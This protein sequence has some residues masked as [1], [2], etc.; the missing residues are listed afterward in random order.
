MDDPHPKATKRKN[1]SD[2]IGFIF[3][4]QI[5]EMSE[6]YGVPEVRLDVSTAHQMGNPTGRLAV[7]GTLE[8][9]EVIV[10]PTVLDNL[11]TLLDCRSLSNLTG[12]VV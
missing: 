8:D 6:L 12:P 5:R 10:P 4:D 3:P 11:I 1:P 9:G 7:G 2:Y